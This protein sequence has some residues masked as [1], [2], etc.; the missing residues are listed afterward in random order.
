MSLAFLVVIRMILAVS[1]SHGAH[2]TGDAVPIFKPMPLVAFSVVSNGTG[3]YQGLRCDQAL[4]SVHEKRVLA[5][6]EVAPILNRE[7]YVVDL[8]SIRVIPFVPY[9]IVLVQDQV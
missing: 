7:R 9:G 5:V 8:T 2:G 3:A 1:L 4:A 6:G